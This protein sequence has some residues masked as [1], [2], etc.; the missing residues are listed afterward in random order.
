MT[1]VGE[2]ITLDIIGTKKEYSSS[3]FEK[4]VSSLNICSRKWITSQYDSMVGTINM[5]TNNPSDA[6]VVNLKGTNKALF[7]TVDC[8]GKYVH[9]DPEIGAM[10]AVSEAARNIVCSGGIPLA[11]T[12]CLNFGN[13]YN[14]ETKLFLFLIL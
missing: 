7:M 1:K 13:P 4:L 2:H 3:F 9:A 5:S 10:I 11:I 14:P 12:N 6:A 8:N